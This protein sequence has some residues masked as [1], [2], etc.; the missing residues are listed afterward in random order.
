MNSKRKTILTAAMLLAIIL[1]AQC[2]DSPEML[3]AS[4]T[5]THVGPAVWVDGELELALWIQ[6]IEEDPVDLQVLL[7]SGEM[8][9]G[10]GGHGLV[11]LTTGAEFPGQ[12]HLLV[13]E[14]G[15]VSGGETLTLIAVDFEENEGKPVEF[16]VPA[17]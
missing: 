14:T 13:F 9:E 7:A 15:A 10:V 2:G 3:N 5:V 16:E 11:G 6:D 1:G 8:L 4:P 17:K 12:S